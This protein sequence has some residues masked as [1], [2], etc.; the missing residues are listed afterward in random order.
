[1]LPRLPNELPPPALASAGPGDKASARTA[2]PASRTG[3]R[4]IAIRF[5]VMTTNM[6]HPERQG[7]GAVDR[8]RRPHG[9]A[10]RPIATSVGDR[11]RL[12]RKGPMSTRNRDDGLRGPRLVSAVATLAIAIGMRVRCAMGS[13]NG[14]VPAIHPGV[15]SRVR[16]RRCGEAAG[17]VTAFG[18]NMVFVDMKMPWMDGIDATL[19][20][21]EPL[22]AVPKACATA[23]ATAMDGDC[24]TLMAAHLL[25]EHPRADGNVWANQRGS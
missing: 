20:T 22:P 19:A 6:V 5:K 23:T 24:E 16:W 7:Q 13:P 25:A 1:M 18:Y 10:T 8:G 17:S 2:K 14:T 12:S 21:R 3:M 9:D 11:D 4:R 15:Q